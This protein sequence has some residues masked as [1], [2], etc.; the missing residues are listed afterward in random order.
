MDENNTPT[1]KRVSAI[2]DKWLEVHRGET[3]DLDLICRQLQIT[4]RENRQF[5]AIKL[6]HEV[7]QQKLEKLNRIYRYVNKD[8]DVIDW[9]NSDAEKTLNLKFPQGRDGTKFGFDGCVC[10]S[11]GDIIVVAGVSNMGKGHPVGTPILTL[12]GW[13]NIEHIQL[14]EDVF[15]QD[16]ERHSITGI[17]PR[18]K[19]PCYR[20]TFTDKSSVDVDGDHLWTIRK[21]WGRKNFNWLTKSTKEII[22]LYGYFGKHNKNRIE[23]PIC[24]PLNF[25]REGVPLSPYLLGLLLGDGKLG[26][27]TPT[28]STAE[29]EM[30]SEFTRQGFSVSQRSKYDYGISGILDIVRNLGIDKGSRDK[31]IPSLYKFNAQEIRLAVLRGLMDTDGYI[32]K[33]G[34]CEFTSV[35][36]QLAEDV[37]F[38]VQSLGGR[39]SF[40]TKAFNKYTH[41]GESRLGQKSYRVG[42]MIDYNPFALPRKAGN[43]KPPSKPRNRAIKH[44]E[45]IGEFETICIQTDAKD[46]LYLTKDCIVTHNT[47]FAQNFLWE[48]M[49]SYPC[50]LMGNEYTPVKFKRRIGRM[51]WNNPLKEDGKPKFELIRRLENW[52]DIVEPDKITIIDWIALPANELYNIGHVIQGIQ[53]KVGN[54]VALIVLQKDESSNLGRGRAFSEELS[55]LYLTIDKGRMT[56]RK[57]KEWFGHDPNR[58]VYG[59]DITNGGVEFRNIRPMV[60]CFSCH[61]SGQSKGGECYSCHGTGYVE[62]ANP[63]Q[64]SEFDF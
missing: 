50:V 35:S 30:L 38:L 5:V 44:I 14:K 55:S 49:D 16:G 31:F 1:Y 24:E 57:A 51:T 22:D 4:E 7:K 9:A 2:V 41:N 36:K 54:G 56:V 8:K 34:W 18:G 39:V 23:I 11:P 10:I 15:G 62:K 61:G 52:A 48:N 32:S 60:K 6:A 43:W 19:Q 37:R 47:T 63:P 13:K 21:R 45:P 26:S 59:F 53:S 3:F 40:S 33:Q 42:F 20:F 64:E 46:G 28:F 27:G 17:F 29:K 25:P 12:G 58:E